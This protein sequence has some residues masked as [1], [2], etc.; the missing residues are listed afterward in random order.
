[1]TRQS[2][3]PDVTRRNDGAYWGAALVLAMRAGDN[4]RAD[5]A[6]RHLRRLGYRLDAPRRQASKGKE[7]QNGR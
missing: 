7:L 6:R 4:A 5:L 1:M 2:L 3:D